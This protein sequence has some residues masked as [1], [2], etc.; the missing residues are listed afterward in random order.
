MFRKCF[1]FVAF[2]KFAR[3]GLSKSP[4]HSVEWYPP[5][6]VKEKFRRVASVRIPS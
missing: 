2:L 1:Y 4:L 6:K 5:P 3:I